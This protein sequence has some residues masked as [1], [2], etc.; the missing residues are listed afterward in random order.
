MTVTQTCPIW[1]TMHRIQSQHFRHADSNLAANL[2]NPRQQPD[3]SCLWRTT[4]G[5][6][7]KQLL[8][9]RGQVCQILKWA[10]QGKGR[11]T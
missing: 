8:E 5:C 6:R 7:T 11:V 4:R 3:P 2:A 1:R 9:M 10:I